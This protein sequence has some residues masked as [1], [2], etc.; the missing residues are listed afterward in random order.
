MNTRLNIQHTPS[1]LEKEL[2]S[3]REENRRIKLHVVRVQNDRDVFRKESNRLLER[4]DKL[5]KK[6]KNQAKPK[7][8]RKPSRDTV[9]QLTTLIKKG[10]QLVFQTKAH[11]SSYKESIQ[12]ALRLPE[13]QVRALAG[14]RVAF[15]KIRLQAEE[16]E[17]QNRLKKSNRKMAHAKAERRKLMQKHAGHRPR[18]SQSGIETW[19]TN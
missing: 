9:K 3:L 19:L 1:E 14:I 13:S 17:L 11:L 12:K 8:K 4:C 10:T 5:Q 16:K 7:L 18:P 15:T 2:R 6:V